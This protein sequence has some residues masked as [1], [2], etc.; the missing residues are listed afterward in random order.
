MIEV[1]RVPGDHGPDLDRTIALKVRELVAAMRRGQA[2]R[3]E[4]AQLLQVAE[5]V[6]EALPP[7]AAQPT[8]ASPSEQSEATGGLPPTW[9]TLAF[10]GVRLGS[11]PALG[12][13]RWGFGLGA[14]P[15]LELRELRVA[16]LLA[17]D[18]FPSIEVEGAS[19]RIRF[20]EWAASPALH[21]Q[22]RTGA[23]W[24]GARLGPQL[25]GLG[26]RGTT[27]GGV[28]G[29]ATPTSWALIVGLDADV[30]LTSRV[31]LIAGVQLQALASRLHLAVNAQD[32]V[33]LGRVRAR[34]GLDLAARF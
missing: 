22:R 9:G 23:I 21:A 20:W 13:G 6:S 11:Q 26:A 5:P 32:L 3:P 14:G 30:M 7:S 29:S 19:D 18:M 17:F 10:A 4:A 25:V 31:S 34:I 24:L 2:A 16:V 28:A 15:R 27:R 33:D 12:L 1:V 8:A